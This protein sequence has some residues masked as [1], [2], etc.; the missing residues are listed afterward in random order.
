M[1]KSCNLPDE[2][3]RVT[4]RS[5]MNLSGVR[6]SLKELSQQRILILDGAMGTSLQAMQLE[7]SDFRGEVLLHHP[8]PLLGNYDVL[9]LSNPHLVKQV[10]QSY[11]SAGADLITTNTFNSNV[12]S[13]ERYGLE[14]QVAELNYRGAR[15]AREMADACTTR[16][17]WVVGS[18]GPTPVP[19][20]LIARTTSEDSS[21]ATP[22]EDF[23]AATSSCSDSRLSQRLEEA[24]NRMVAAYEVQAK[25]LL[26]GGADLLLLETC[27]DVMNAQAALTAIRRLEQERMSA[28][29]VMVSVTINP[30][31]CTFTGQTL[32][33]IY[34]RVSEFPIFSFGINCSFGIDGLEPYLKQLSDALPCLI[35]CHPNAGFPDEQG[36]YAMTPSYMAECMR[37]FAVKGYLNIAGGCCG[38]TAAH[39]T[40]MAEALQ[41]VEPHKISFNEY[42]NSQF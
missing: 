8:F 32:N 19:L 4:G 41:D 42:S 11:V 14:N 39:I 17:V 24:F 18:M 15:L 23:S 30:N 7:E 31:G 29:L 21:L 26:D 9:N 20:S 28:I 10:H 27:Y 22:S 37:A 16:K 13:Q 40:A 6:Q 36:V 1:D 34:A 2:R 12:L 25:G 33:E 5:S 35:S 3:H 38:T